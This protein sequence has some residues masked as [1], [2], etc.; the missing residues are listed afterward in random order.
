M[1]NIK[2]FPDEIE[3]GL[4]K[5]ISNN[6]ATCDVNLRINISEDIFKIARASLDVNSFGLYR[7]PSILAS[8]GWNKNTDVF[9]PEELWN[10]RN[11]PV[12]K[13]VNMMHKES[14]IIGHTIASYVVT[15]DGNLWT[16]DTCPTM[17]FDIID[18]SVIYTTYEEQD[19]LEKIQ[20]LIAE[21]EEGKWFVS[22][23][24]LFP[25]FDY[26][27]KHSDGTE[28][29]VS[30]NQETA[31]LTKYL[32]VYGGPGKFQ[33]KAIGR[34]L[35]NFVFSGK[36]VVD[37]PANDRSIILNTKQLETIKSGEE[38][39]ELET[40]LAEATKNHETAVA[41]LNEA[42]ASNEELKETVATL[43]STV[44]SLTKEVASLKEALDTEVSKAQTLIEELNSSKAELNSSK[45]EV[46]KISR[47]IKLVKAGLED[48]SEEILNKF[49]SV[50]EEVFD[51]FVALAKKAECKEEPAKDKKAEEMTKETCS[52]ASL[53]SVEVPNEASLATAG[54]S[55]TNEEVYKSAAAWVGNI[56]NNKVRK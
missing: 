48:R 10:A 56:I 33:G 15:Q 47:A 46:L 2:I 40:K 34:V 43:Q 13:P 12:N 52:E 28:E 37:N 14:H 20:K 22:M 18:D 35:R 26:S 4:E 42:N 8:V 41:N 36:G 19:N 54:V 27:L 44:E 24:C 11:S 31:F 50:S 51:E 38:M 25:N 16:G 29:I 3:A 1:I 7:L 49:S 45:A 30:R 5:A 32:K 23:E 21:I 39:E 9:L 53:D 6:I 55:D 17:P